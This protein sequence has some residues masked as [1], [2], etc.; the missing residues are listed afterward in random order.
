MIQQIK[1]C[2]K[3]LRTLA[4]CSVAVSLFGFKSGAYTIKGDIKANNGT[5]FYLT[6]QYNGKQVK[7]SA[8]ISANQF[9]FKGNLPEPVICTLSNSVNQ[10]MR[11]FIAENSEIAV[12]GSIEK[13]YSAEV[14]GSAE[15]ALYNEFKQ[16][17]AILS[18]QYRAAV[19][20]SGA[21][22]HN[23]T[24]E[25]YKVFHTRLDSLTSAFVKNNSSTTAAALA[26][27]DC[28]L[29]NPDRPNAKLCYALLS[30]KGQQSVYAKRVLQFV[31]AATNISPGHI[32]PDFE[33]KDINGKSQKL[34][35]YRG[36]Y[37]LLDFWASWCA[38]CRAE[39]PNLKR[40]YQKYA[41][42]NFKFIGVSM[43]AGQ[44][45]WKQAISIDGLPWIQLN[46]PWSMNGNLAESYGV[47]AIPFNC[48]INPQGVI[49]AV[50]LRGEAL[51]QYLAAHFKAN[52]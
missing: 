14:K 20:A 17:D 11:L 28:Y 29:T 26:I 34:S 19:K 43:D 3:V 38:P 49:E 18:G 52:N 8:I 42:D 15:D 36:K 5:V 9:L 39:H 4:L 41:N 23:K 2:A 46:D 22:L 27:F 21:D 30:P 24:S 1:T 40:C 44:A 33:L 7:D 25:P 6:Y 51:T 37:V 48:I 47:K 50:N 12:N 10:Q 13:L 32:A 31:N 35:D 45:Q 16:Q